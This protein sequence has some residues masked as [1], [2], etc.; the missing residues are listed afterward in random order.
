[1]TAKVSVDEVERV[2]ALANLE[3]EPEESAH[4]VHD[5]NAILDYVAQLN[6]LDTAGVAPLAQVTELATADGTSVLRT[7]AKEPSL[8][9]EVVMAQAPETDQVFFKVPKV[10][11]R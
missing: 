3:L 5:L 9:R 8:D 6:E 11:E 7:D 1:M 4:M 10:I 2:A